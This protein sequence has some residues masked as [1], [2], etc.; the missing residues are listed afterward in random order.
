MN[1]AE[2]SPAITSSSAVAQGRAAALR[3]YYELTKPRLSMLAVMTAMTGY[4]IAHVGFQVW[5]FI[6]LLIGTSCAAGGSAAVNQWIERNA[7]A[8]MF[9]TRGRP[10]PSGQ[11][12][13]SGALIFGLVLCGVGVAVVF[14]GSNAIAGL[15]T[16]M[17]VVSYLA[18]YTPLKTITPLNTEVGTIPGALPPLIGWTAAT[19]SLDALGVWLFGLLVIWQLPHFLAIS[20]ICREDYRRGG[21]LM[22]ATLNEDGHQ[23]ARYAF[24]TALLLFVVSLL[25]WFSGD[26]GAFYGVLATALGG[27]FVAKT[28]P[29][30]R[31]PREKTAKALFFTSIIYLPL[32]LLALLADRLL[33]A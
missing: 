1:T 23:C 9:R 4:A 33:F 3:G 13:P 11:V 32:I 30:L 10:I 19:G 16:L 27:W 6:A 31:D 25:P 24:G 20:W 22:L 21:F 17:T 15:L 2:S 26:L 12:K 5:E 18:V 14:A 8:R 29:F 28:I 7:D